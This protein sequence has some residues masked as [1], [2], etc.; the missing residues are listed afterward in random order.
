VDANP[1]MINQTVKFYVTIK[2]VGHLDNE[3]IAVFMDNGTNFGMKSYSAKIDGSLEEIWSAWTPKVAGSH[4]VK[5]KLVPDASMNDPALANYSSQI[6]VYVDQD[7]DGDGIRDQLDP[8]IDNDGL[9]NE[10][11]RAIG[12]D[13]YKADTDGDGVNDKNDY[14]PLD[15]S[16]WKKEAPVV[17]Q[18]QQTSGN[19]Q[20]S[21]TQTAP[22]VAKATAKTTQTPTTKITVAAPPDEPLST[23]QIQTTAAAATSSDLTAIEPTS[24]VEFIASTSTETVTSTESLPA[25]PFDKGDMGDKTKNGFWNLNA[26]LWGVAV[27]CGLVAGIFTWLAVKKKRTDRS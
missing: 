2:N 21:Q 7:T 9:T 16:R 19:N 13:P 5:V 3:G 18:T 11:E 27:I 20:G 1:V 12:T 14:Y 8:D 25:S 22:P 4:V 15:P 23:S 24:T 17:T 10:E 6:T 26:L